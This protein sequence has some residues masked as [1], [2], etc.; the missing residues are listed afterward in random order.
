MV[1]VPCDMCLSNKE[2]SRGH[3]LTVLWHFND[4]KISC[5]DKVEVTKLILILY[6]QKMY[7]EKMM[8]HCGGKGK[9]FGMMLQLWT[10]S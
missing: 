5:K 4:P 7:G 9:Y 2:T 6:L 1:M 8:L 3:Q 10:K